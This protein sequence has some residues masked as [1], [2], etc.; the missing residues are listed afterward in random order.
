MVARGPAPHRLRRGGAHVA[1]H[2]RLLAASSR[3][4]RDTVDDPTVRGQV[5]V[6]LPSLRVDAFTVGI[7]AQIAEG[8]PH[9]AHVRARGRHAGA[10]AR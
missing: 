10:C 9:R 7:A 6:S 5:S 2:R 3:S 8:P 1:V 4:S